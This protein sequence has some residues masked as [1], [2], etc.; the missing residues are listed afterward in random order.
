M[1]QTWLEALF[2]WIHVVAGVAWIGH[3][4]FFNFVNAHLAKTYDPDTRRKVVP[5]LMP[6]ALYWFRWGAVYTY[7]TGILLAGMLYWS[8]EGLARQDLATGAGVIAHG[9]AVLISILLLVGAF[10]A[11]EGIMRALGKRERVAVGALFALLVAVVLVLSRLFSGRAVFIQA[12]MMLGTIMI[13][14]VWMRI[15]PAQRKIIQAAAG[16][17]PAPDGSLGVQVALRSK[18]NTY[19]SVALLFTMV[20]N[21]YP[22]LYGADQAWIIL[23]GAFALSFAAAKLLFL[24]SAGA[25]PARFGVPEATH[26]DTGHGMAAPKP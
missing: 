15:W 17:A 23:C 14:N 24:K 10:P 18:H 1:T 25:A 3:L 16:L 12:G 13:A 6:R 8:V 4:Y 11:Y 21:H 20:S 9:P 7:L 26:V 5:Q 19:L 2:R 22:V